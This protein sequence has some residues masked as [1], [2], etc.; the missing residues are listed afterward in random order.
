[1]IEVLETILR[2]RDVDKE[3]YHII[4]FKSLEVGLKIRLLDKD[5]DGKPVEVGT[6]LEQDTFDASYPP[7]PSP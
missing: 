6:V 2:Q 7:L 5:T 3:L 1:M 4:S